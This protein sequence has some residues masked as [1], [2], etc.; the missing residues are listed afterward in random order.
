LFLGSFFL[1]FGYD[2]L[3]KMLMEFTGS[4]WIAD[5]IFYIISASFFTSYFLLK[6]YRK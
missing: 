3:F 4:Y 6:K 5:F 2:G 1:P